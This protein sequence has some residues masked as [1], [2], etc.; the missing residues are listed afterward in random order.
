MRLCSAT[1]ATFGL[2]SWRRPPPPHQ[3]LYPHLLFLKF[4]V[5][6]TYLYFLQIMPLK[7]R[8]IYVFTR[9]SAS[10]VAVLVFVLRHR[11][12]GFAVF[13]SRFRC[14]HL[15]PP[16]CCLPPISTQ[17]LQILRKMINLQIRLG[18][19]CDT[20]LLLRI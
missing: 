4:K 10:C 14:S 5:L 9:C 18:Q 16:P 3:I 17:K 1:S 11:L 2:R 8:H 13:C 12:C 7:L 20:G 19:R 15:R 6:K